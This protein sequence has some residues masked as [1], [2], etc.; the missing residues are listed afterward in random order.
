MTQ[1]VMSG[2]ASL[3]LPSLESKQQ[4]TPIVEMSTGSDSSDVDSLFDEP[5]EGLPA[6]L[7]DNLEPFTAS[8][9]EP[10]PPTNTLP[11]LRLAPPIPGL[12]F[13]P[14]ILLPDELAETL[15]QKCIEMYFQDENVNQIM[16][17]ERVVSDEQALTH[18]PGTPHHDSARCLSY[19]IQRPFQRPRAYPTF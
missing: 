11:A 19:I 2:P 5:T 12:Y 14:S 13:D 15:L 3:I 10:P 16:L 6:E 8:Y 18:S 7:F 17:F 1:V 9:T 4:E